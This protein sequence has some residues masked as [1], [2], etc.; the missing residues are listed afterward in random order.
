MARQNDKIMYAHGELGLVEARAFDVELRWLVP[1]HDEVT[2]THCVVATS[3]EAAI[4]A[5]FGRDL[6]AALGEPLGDGAWAV[7]LYYKPMVRWIWVGGLIMALGGLLA[8]FDRRYR[9]SS[10]REEEKA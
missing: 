1:K 10:R 4:D 6:Y 7:S 3:A 2:E 8:M 5:G 9:L